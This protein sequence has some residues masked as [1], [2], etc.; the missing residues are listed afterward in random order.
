MFDLVRVRRG[1]VSSLDARSG[2]L[3]THGTPV[4]N[5]TVRVVIG[6]TFG[7][8]VEALGAVEADGLAPHMIESS[9]S[10]L[11]LSLEIRVYV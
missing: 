8:A 2:V 10:A 7:S 3:L 1:V 5:W 4:P 6:D 11:G 9:L